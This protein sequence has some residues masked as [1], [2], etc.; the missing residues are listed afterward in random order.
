MARPIKPKRV[1]F[2][3][4]VVYFKP[5]VVPLSMLKEVDLNVDELEALRLRFKRFRS[6]ISGKKD[7]N[8]SEYSSAYFNLCSQK[9][10]RSGS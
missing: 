7:E 1:L 2:N 10:S 3:P 4:N 5:R 9:I 6:K 8:F